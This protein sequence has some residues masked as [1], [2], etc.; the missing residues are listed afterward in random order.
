LER[1][2]KRERK[3]PEQAIIEKSK[4]IDSCLEKQR[5]IVDAYLH[6]RYKE[7]KKYS[8]PSL[9]SISECIKS[10]IQPN[11]RELIYNQQI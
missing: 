8:L 3:V 4:M 11:R 7:V 9:S 2:K 6:I 5:A 10:I 1:N